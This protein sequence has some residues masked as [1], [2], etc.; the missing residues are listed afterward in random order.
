MQRPYKNMAK[1]VAIALLIIGCIPTA[2][3]TC[4]VGPGLSPSGF[5]AFV[6]MKTSQNAK[7][8]NQAAPS[9]VGPLRSNAS[10]A[11]DKAKTCLKKER[12]GEGLRA[13][14]EFWSAW[15]EFINAMDDDKQSDKAIEFKFQQARMKY[16]VFDVVN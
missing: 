13:L 4:D 16:N 1:E 14:G 9:C 5:D 2:F 6:C 15:T 7:M 8:A 12:N 3:A 10:V 11:M